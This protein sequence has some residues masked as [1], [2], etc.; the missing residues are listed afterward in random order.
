MQKISPFW[1]VCLLCISTLQ[2]TAA[3]VPQ[4]TPAKNSREA[5][6]VT[7]EAVREAEDL[8]QLL[9][10]PAE[11]IKEA[12]KTFTVARALYKEGLF[13]ECKTVLS[14]FWKAHPRTSS[15]WES[16]NEEDIGYK[17]GYPCGYPALLMLEDAVDWRLKAMDLKTPIEARD[18]SLAALLVGK[19]KGKMP[20][21]DAEAKAGRGVDASATLDPELLLD[22]NRYLHDLLWLTREYYLGVTEGKVLLHFEVFYLKDFEFDVGAPGGPN[23]QPNN[24]NRLAA[25]IPAHIAKRVDWYWAIY[26]EIEPGP[27]SKHY[28]ACYSPGTDIPG[29]M[30]IMPE[31]NSPLFFCEDHF[32]TR[33]TISQ[34][35][36]KNSPLASQI[37]IPYW[38]QHEFFHDHFANYSS[39][40]LEEEPHQWFNRFK[41]P[42][43]FVGK[44]E[45]DY[46][47]EA[48]FKRL[49]KEVNLPFSDYFFRRDFYMGWSRTLDLKD[50]AGSYAM[51]GAFNDWHYGQITLEGEQL[52]WVNKAR[53]S[54]GLTRTDDDKLKTS[55]DNPYVKERSAFK[56]LPV[57]GPD[58]KPT[59]GIKGFKFGNETYLRQ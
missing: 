58:Q 57:L 22:Q 17:L 46:Y 30:T 21:N 45:P 48:M 27:G 50:F 56:L 53:K 14:D 52:K 40:K 24:F 25:A 44:Y 51:E 16:K 9:R 8:I 12:V 3:V 18:W 20:A 5:S 36:G 37:Y 31:T 59:G 13:Q 11:I 47:Q 41:W 23:H 26:P 43:D 35:R 32:L 1:I 2:V 55:E 33:R 54:W 15:E 19:S 38:H 49:K 28:L 7:K 4:W 42:K 6:V 34:G 39:L 10:D 29:G